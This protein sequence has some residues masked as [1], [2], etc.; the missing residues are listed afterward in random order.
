VV[1]DQRV[2]VASKLSGYIREILVQEGDRM[3]RGQVLAGLLR[4]TW[5]VPAA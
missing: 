4:R 5:K 2:D 1:S 3:H